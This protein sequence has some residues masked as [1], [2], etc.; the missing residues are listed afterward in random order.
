MITHSSNTH[1]RK[2]G[3]KFPGAH[4]THWPFQGSSSREACT[5]GTPLRASRSSALPPPPRPQCVCDTNRCCSSR[6]LLTLHP[7][8]G[9]TRWMRPRTEQTQPPLGRSLT[10]LLPAG[11]RCVWLYSLG[12]AARDSMSGST[13]GARR[14][15][16]G[17]RESRE[18]VPSLAA[19]S[20]TAM[21]EGDGL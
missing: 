16:V 20:G 3:G 19:A 13:C 9:S 21:L 17:A 12:R 18:G 1:A 7:P 5:Y 11:W 4:I 8:L 15:W 14:G 6:E 2:C 10:P